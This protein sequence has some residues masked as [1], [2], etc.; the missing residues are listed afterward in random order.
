M[1]LPMLEE[2]PLNIHKTTLVKMTNTGLVRELLKQTTKRTEIAN[3]TGLHYNIKGRKLLT[4]QDCTTI[5]C[6]IL[7]IGSTKVI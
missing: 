1:S 4:S 6:V 2:T 7:S 3:I 5:R